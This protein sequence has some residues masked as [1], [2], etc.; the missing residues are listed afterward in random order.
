MKKFT[1]TLNQK[2]MHSVKPTNAAAESINTCTPVETDINNFIKMV[3]QPQGR[4]WCAATFK[5]NKRKNDMWTEQQVFALDF[6]NGMIP[7]ETLELLATYNIIPNI[8]Y[9][10][11]SDSAE[12]RK[13]RLIFILKEK[14][15]SPDL[16]KWIIVNLMGLFGQKADKAC[17]DLCRL[18]YG[19]KHSEAEF[20]SQEFI[21]NEAFIN[22][23]A[24]VAASDA[25]KKKSSLDTAFAP[26]KNTGIPQTPYIYK[27]DCGFSGF[28]DGGILTAHSINDKVYNNGELIREFDFDKA[29]ENVQVFADFIAG[30]WLF[31][32]ELFGL[33]TNLRW[34]EGGMKLMKETMNKWNKAGKTRYSSNNFGILPYVGKMKYTP[35]NLSGFSKYED[36]HQ[37]TNIISSVKHLQG[38]VTPLTVEP[39]ISIQEAEERL[40]TQF[41]RVLE[42]EEKGKIFIFRV[43]TGLGKTELL[44]SV[45]NA[46]IALPTHN[47]KDEV[48]DRMKVESFKVTPEVPD[49]TQE[50]KSQIEKLYAKGLQQ[51][52][53]KLIL[54]IAKNEK[55]R[56]RVSGMFSGCTNTWEAI[57]SEADVEL[58]KEYVAVNT[59]CYKS[60]D[61]VL[62]THT[63]AMFVEF[64]TDTL[65]F[66]EDPMQV[67]L[68]IGNIKS[69]EFLQ[70][71]NCMPESEGVLKTALKAFYKI[72]FV[73]SVVTLGKNMELIPYFVEKR[74]VI[75][76]VILNS[77]NN[78]QNSNF[79]SFLDCKNYAKDISGTSINYIIKRDIKGLENKKVIIMSATAS[80]IVY[81]NLGVDV[82]IIDLGKV[83]MTGE[84][85]QNTRYSM[86]K[87]SLNSK[88]D[89]LVE[90]VGELPVITFADTKYKFKNAVTEMHFG[91][92]S[93][94]DILKGKDIAVVGTFNRP[95][96]VYQLTAQ[97]LGFELSNQDFERP[98]NQLV[99]YNNYRFK[100]NTFKSKVL[101]QIQFDYIN[102]DLVQAV[103]RARTLR[104]NCTVYLYSGFPLRETTKMIR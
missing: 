97:A 12:L 9:G 46:T 32:N 81:K 20:V 93:G 95:T 69:D 26:L 33:A 16:A 74:D 50:V 84:I 65:I 104:E 70:V 52:V 102:Q 40:K 28:S 90:K 91:N 60:A 59:E 56:V 86:S 61:T 13:F 22:V 72:V 24:S 41:K 6:D 67:M 54:S 14:V 23:L 101:Q 92:C 3:C 85:I 11:F 30:E 45:T 49:F 89:L 64:S 19:S 34:I 73:D 82:E 31:H 42:S 88:I 8:I 77:K 44:T 15:T 29:A 103:G 98:D 63:K 51:D 18:F 4:T 38:S 100:C 21:D 80:E 76:A 10:S 47:L 71:I 39:V 1:V 62:T 87:Q 75:R 58:A 66:D 99:E 25:E 2:V 27:E 5:D 53:N 17:K 83:K 36:D 55:Q 57:Y 79:L 35:S 94:Y 37:F 43:P 7:E 68:P 78:I 96:F 48:A